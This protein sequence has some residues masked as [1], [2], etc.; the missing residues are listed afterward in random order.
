MA[1]QEQDGWPRASMPNPQSHVTNVDEV[2]CESLEHRFKL[3]V[4]AFVNPCDQA[5][6]G[7]VAEPATT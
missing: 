6:A 5:D 7:I 4:R 3:T 2:K 1:M